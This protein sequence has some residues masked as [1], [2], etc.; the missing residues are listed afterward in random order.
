MR[1]VFLFLMLIVLE[2]WSIIKVGQQIG[3]LATLVLLVAGF[4]F[5]SQVLRAQGIASLI[6]SAQQAQAGKSPLNAI[7]GG[8]ITAFAGILLII[9]GFVSD[10]IAI[11]L[12]V[13]FVR[14]AL[15]K[16]MLNKGNIMGFAAGGFAK[17]GFGRGGF[18]P[19]AND[20]VMG[21]NIYEHD[22]PASSSRGV[23]ERSFIEQK[24]DVVDAEIIEDKPEKNK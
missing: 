13:P 9:P 10:I 6:Q 16:R 24:D 17:A 15:V 19:G 5:G 3:V 7:A 1:F 18:K 11:I 4:V 14:N 23:K 20:D 2:I 21:G 12:L 8:L 22:G